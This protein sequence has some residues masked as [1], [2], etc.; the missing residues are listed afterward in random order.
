[1]LEPRIKVR[2]LI[3]GGGIRIRVECTPIDVY[4]HLT[5]I[6]LRVSAPL[7]VVVHYVGFSRANRLNQNRTLRFRT[8]RGSVMRMSHT[9]YKD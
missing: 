4:T 9:V 8:L 2:F 3:A 6:S 7:L 5:L 1:M